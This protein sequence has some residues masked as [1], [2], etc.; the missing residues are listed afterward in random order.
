MQFPQMK[1]KTKPKPDT[2]C[3]FMCERSMQKVHLSSSSQLSVICYLNFTALKSGLNTKT[4]IS[5]KW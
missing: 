1:R 5:V 2:H 3:C 4:A